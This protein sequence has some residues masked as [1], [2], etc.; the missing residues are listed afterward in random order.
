MREHVCSSLADQRSRT[1]EEAQAEG[2][3]L[4]HLF[5]FRQRRR[6]MTAEDVVMAAAPP[7]AD[8]AA[9]TTDAP[10]EAPAVAAVG[11]ENKVRL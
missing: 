11:T 2:P 7:V 8:A 3:D 6:P 10:A 1:T 5:F 4:P 9:P